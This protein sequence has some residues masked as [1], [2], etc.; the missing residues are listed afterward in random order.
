MLQRDFQTHL[1]ENLQEHLKLICNEIIIQRAEN[2]ELKTI[3]RDLQSNQEKL[4]NDYHKYRSKT[5][6][7]TTTVNQLT[8]ESYQLKNE[9]HKLRNIVKARQ[10]Q[11]SAK[12]DK[13]KNENNIS[14][15]SMMDTI[16]QGDLSL[17]PQNSRREVI[18]N[19]TLEELDNQLFS[20]LELITPIAFKNLTRK[21]SNLIDRGLQISLL[22]E[23]AE[24][25]ILEELQIC[26]E[27]DISL[28]D[29]IVR[30]EDSQ[31]N[32]IRKCPSQDC[33][34]D[35][36]LQAGDLE[37]NKCFEK[38][39]LEHFPQS[40]MKCG[41]QCYLRTCQEK[42]ILDL[43]NNVRTCTQHS[44]S[45][46][47]CLH[48]KKWRSLDP[49]SK[50]KCCCRDICI[51]CNRRQ[52]QLRSVENSVTDVICDHDCVGCIYEGC[53]SVWCKKCYKRIST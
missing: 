26:E 33:N 7:L 40:T 36:R 47:F 5:I 42:T 25:P 51:G 38:Y 12:T 35:L 52:Q 16:H 31:I 23:D 41:C 45:F 19:P 39:C 17:L 6:K 22:K 49:T 53:N 50:I 27:I 20:S 3:I 30:A 9:V 44:N 13:N 4:L 28:E 2:A 32:D 15:S 18:V 37:C 29:G 43:Q 10:R 14:S 24:S 48:C 11:S 8:A 46:H 1:S 21:T 34:N